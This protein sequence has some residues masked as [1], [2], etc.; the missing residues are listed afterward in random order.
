M[1]AQD[2][3]ELLE[4]HQFE[5]FE[6]M[7][8]ISNLG[9]KD[10][11]TILDNKELILDRF[12]LPEW[13]I[14]RLIIGLENVDEKIEVMENYQLTNYSRVNI[15]ST[16][17]DKSKLGIV[18]T[19][20]R[21]NKY[22][23]L[24]ILSSM[25]VEKISEFF[26]NNREFYT[27]SNI[28]PYEITRKLDNNL[29]I[30]IVGILED[31]N[32]TLDEKREILVTLDPEVK[33]SINT[34]NFPKEY[35]T[36][37]NM[38]TEEYSE[39]IILDMEK[40]LEDYRGLDNLMV[41]NPEQFTE[42]K[43]A[44]FMQLCDICPNMQVISNVDGVDFAST[45]SEY[46]E[47]EEWIESIINNLNPKFSRAQKMAVIDSAIGKKISYSPDF[48]T[49][50]C[51]GDDCRALWKIISSGYGVCN[52][53][54]KVEQYIL[55][56]IGIESEI[57]SG[58]KHV[59]LKIKDIELPLANGKIVKGNTILDPTWN[60][61]AHRFGG[62]PDNFC[63]SYEEIRKNDIDVNGIDYSCHRNDEELQD[64][65][66]NL[67]E[68][69]LRNLFASVG[70]A[71]KDGQFPI[72]GLFE[73]SKLLDEFYKD[74]P[75]KNINEQL[76][77][78]SKV[79][80]EFATCQNSSMSIL[81]DVLLNNENLRFN[82]CVINRVYSRIDKEKRPILYIYIDSNELGKKFYSADKTKGQFIE[83]PQEDFIRQ[84]ECY[85]KDLKKNKRS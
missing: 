1:N 62:K 10:K 45:A 20:E 71:D 13:Q 84:F 76:L 23:K 26:S 2:L 56:R 32:L 66:L 70:L 33:Q 48:D 30:E 5:D 74:Q 47:A 14:S 15:I 27:E 29:Q 82:K 53:I 64:A 63:K 24:E 77:L 39:Q 72:K 85:E 43:R 57:I 31:M 9:N 16:F 35:K 61:T 68:Q 18:L 17:D 7:G 54:A 34:V 42:E 4:K 65:T 79:C 38:Q 12:H 49:E 75:D 3:R 67:D 58:D 60:L 55:G 44:K 73:K 78:F 6:L 83:L 37:V 51:N 8:I 50:V 21:F 46:K 52:G 59:F 81:K 25:S 36:V 19:E 28:H 80:P 40:E 69:S 22:N 41:I 11:K